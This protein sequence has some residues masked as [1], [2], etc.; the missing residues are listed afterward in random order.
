MPP[1]GVR[2]FVLALDALDAGYRIACRE[3][4]GTKR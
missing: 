3:A 4:G 2:I 1:T